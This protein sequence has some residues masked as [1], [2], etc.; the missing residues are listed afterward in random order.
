MGNASSAVYTATTTNGVT[1]YTAYPYPGT[2]DPTTLDVSGQTT[3]EL[4]P[5]PKT[6]LNGNPTNCRYVTVAISPGA[7]SLYALP[8]NG[9]GG[10]YGHSVSDGNSSQYSL[11]GADSSTMSYT[12]GGGLGS[13]FSV[14]STTTWTW[15]NSWSTQWSSGTAN[16]NMV[17]LN[18]SD[19]SCFEEVSFYEDTEYHTMVSVVPDDW[20]SVCP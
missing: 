13:L 11:G 16:S 8:L 20:Q 1:N 7:T 12:V 10:P 19:T 18:T 15:V 2:T 9:P 3:C 5:I 17:N 4:N 6:D 14:K